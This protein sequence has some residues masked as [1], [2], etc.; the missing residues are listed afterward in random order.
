MEIVI[1][2]SAN[3][4]RIYVIFSFFSRFK[5]HRLLNPTPNP[6]H[7]FVSSDYNDPNM[8]KIVV[9]PAKNKLNLDLKEQIHY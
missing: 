2:L 5:S 8:I 3:V 7:Y 6:T 9:Q 1:L 4:L